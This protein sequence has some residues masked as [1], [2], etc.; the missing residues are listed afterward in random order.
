MSFPSFD[1][2]ANFAATTVATAPSPA[3]SG[4]SLVVTTDS[5]LPVPPYDAVV[6]PT[7]SQPTSS[8]AEV[9]R[10]TADSS[11]TLTITRQAEGS[12]ARSITVGDNFAANITLKALTDLQSGTPIGVASSGAVTTSS[13]TTGAVSSGLAFNVVANA[14]YQFQAAIFAFSHATTTTGSQFAVSA[15]TGTTGAWQALGPLRSGAGTTAAVNGGAST[16][17]TATTYIGQ[18][19]ATTVSAPVYLSGR[20]A[21]ATTPGTVT[22]YFASGAAGTT[23]TC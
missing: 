17:L 9:V 3:T 22:I 11:G 8:N 5:V 1:N 10:V 23:V 14:T 6:W 19:A 20:V 21:V 16:D 4:T 13:T 7:G 12:S 18:F 2:M 15:P